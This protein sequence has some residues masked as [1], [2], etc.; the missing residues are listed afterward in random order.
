MSL[1]QRKNFMLTN[2]KK[3]DTF[4]CT[5]KIYPYIS[6]SLENIH[7]KLNVSK[8]QFMFLCQSTDLQ[9]LLPSRT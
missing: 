1:L 5:G 6:M 7:R 4:V 2:E 9:S 8:T 3:L